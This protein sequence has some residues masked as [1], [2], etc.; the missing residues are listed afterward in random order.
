MVNSQTIHVLMPISTPIITKSVEVITS[1]YPLLVGYVPIALHAFFIGFAEYI[2][3]EKLKNST[4]NNQYIRSSDGRRRHGSSLDRKILVKRRDLNFF[5]HV[6]YEKLPAYCTYCLV[7][8]CSSSARSIS[9]AKM[10]HLLLRD[11]I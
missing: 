3:K 11:R 10:Q 2:L 4:S 5:L 9:Q 6:E 7:K 1:W 8:G